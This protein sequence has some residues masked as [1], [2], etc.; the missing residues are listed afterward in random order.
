MED[1]QS[2]LKLERGN[3]RLGGEM[4][5]EYKVLDEHGLL[6]TSWNLRTGNGGKKWKKLES[7]VFQRSTSLAT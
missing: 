1:G 6:T 3:P 4:L 7:L 5:Q 2:C